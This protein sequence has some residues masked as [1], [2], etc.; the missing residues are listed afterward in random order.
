[1]AVLTRIIYVEGFIFSFYAQLLN[2]RQ[3][4]LLLVLV[5]LPFLHEE[6]FFSQLH[7]SHVEPVVLLLEETSPSWINVS[8]RKREINPFSMEIA[9]TI[10][11]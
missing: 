6:A 5:Q 11:T 4:R 7:P 8:F 3:N 9:E 10:S 1:M 2:R